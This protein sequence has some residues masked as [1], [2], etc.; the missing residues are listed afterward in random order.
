MSLSEQT[1]SFT[2][3]VPA[4]ESFPLEQI[5]ECAA[6]AVS[7]PHGTQV[8][9]YGKSFGFPLLREWLAARHGVGAEQVMLANGS[10][11]AAPGTRLNSA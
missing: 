5:A 8:M 3:G 2:R 6:A 9:Q 11:Q 1:I 7:G 4:D 10:L